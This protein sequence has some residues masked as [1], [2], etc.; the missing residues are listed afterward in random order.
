MIRLE[1]CFA[2]QVLVRS[3]VVVPEA[4]QVKL[5]LHLV[6]IEQQAFGFL[7]QG[8]KKP[9]DSAILPRMPWLAALMF[10]AQPPQPEAEQP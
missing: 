4:E 1:R 6:L 9:L 8:T 5:F 10:Y 3:D 7:L 2:V